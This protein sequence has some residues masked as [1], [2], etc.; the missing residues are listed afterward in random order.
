VFTNKKREGMD[1]FV[2]AVFLYIAG[3]PKASIND[4]E[5]Q[6]PIFLSAWSRTVLLDNLSRN[7]C[8]PFFNAVKLSTFFDRVASGQEMVGGINS[9][10]SGKSQEI[11]FSLESGKSGV[12]K[13]N[14][15]NWNFMILLKTGR[16]V[17]GH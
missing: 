14:Q 7:S 9:S 12:L 8:K 13:K 1:T 15:E 17:C 4:Q 5:P 3:T 2:C 6:L 10:K 11:N 16:N